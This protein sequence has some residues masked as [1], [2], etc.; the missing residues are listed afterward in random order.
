MAAPKETLDADIRRY[1]E[2]RIDELKLRTV[3]GLSVGVSRLLSLMVAIMLGAIVVA[4]FAFG[5]VLLLGDVIGSWAGAAFIIG[6]LFLVILAIILILWK[7]L[8]VD[9]FV[10]LFISIFYDNE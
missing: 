9:I 5:A 8:F 6:T 2:L 3:D 10:R 7:R 1:L 4:S